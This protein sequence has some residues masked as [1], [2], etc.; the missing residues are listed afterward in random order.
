M[1]IIVV[2]LIAAELFFSSVDSFMSLETRCTVIIV[3]TIVAAGWFSLS[4]DSF[5]S[6]QTRCAMIFVVTTVA[7]KRFSPEWIL[8]CL[9]KH[10]A[11]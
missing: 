8:S 4:V 1:V 7:A 10:T 9:F 6:L 3:V 2:T 5:M 11:R